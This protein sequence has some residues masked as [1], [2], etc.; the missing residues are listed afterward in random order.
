M[1]AETQQAVANSLQSDSSAVESQLSGDEDPVQHQC[2]QEGLETSTQRSK[3]QKA[4]A[5]LHWAHN[6]L[7]PDAPSCFLTVGGSVESQADDSSHP[8]Q[9]QPLERQVQLA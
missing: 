7:L 5:Q 3:Q 9:Q 8:R 1:A 4:H 2:H 6:E